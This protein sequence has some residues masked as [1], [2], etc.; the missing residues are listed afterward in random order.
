MLT[1]AAQLK[2]FVIRA[3]DG[4]LG[5]VDQ[6]YFDDETWAIRY[7]TVD[8][9][10]WLGGRQVLISP[11]SIA[12]TDW[13]ARR[14][15]V[16]LTRK[17]VE[18]S[19]DINTHQPVSRKHEAAFLGHYGYPYYWGGH[20]LWGASFYPAGL[21]MPTTAA[22][23]AMADSV[24]SESMESHLRSSAAV[25]GYHIEAT[26]GEI[27]HVDGFLV[28]DEAWAIRYIEVATRNWWP[29]KK[30]LISPGWIERVSWT[31]SSVYVGLTREA[32]KNG[33]EYVESVPITREYENRLYCH[34]GRP[35]YWVQ[36]AEH[37]SSRSLSGV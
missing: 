12:H 35:P 34:Y 8:T 11:M 13:P 9:G 24:W 29:G 32:I 27:G 33:P 22:R 28:D 36:E 19:P 10:G 1:N 16:A 37:K 23:K 2:G 20:Y 31:D 3:T 18:K 17:Q 21:A 7:L 15:D 4:E 25:A 30:V 5:T 14:L 6:L 26:D